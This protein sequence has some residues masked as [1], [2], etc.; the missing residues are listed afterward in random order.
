MRKFVF[1]LIIFIY[2]FTGEAAD[3]VL[4]NAPVTVCF[5]PQDGCTKAI[6][7]AIGN[8]R[9]EI[10]VQA[11]GFTSKPIA[12]ALAKAKQNGVIITIILDKSNRK[13]KRSAGNFMTTIG[14]S[15][16]IDSK[17]A[18]AHN[19]IMIIDQETVITGSFNFT[20][21]AEYSNA[22]NLLILK[23]KPLAALYIENFKS[24]LHLS[25]KY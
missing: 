11:Y 16:F 25:E 17:P 12:A 18:K 3:L 1:I 15:T 19:K 22:E 20:K 23:S 13:A 9:N 7:Q 4:N 5:S 10:F 24:H 8:A 14:I 2:V 6:V 21:A